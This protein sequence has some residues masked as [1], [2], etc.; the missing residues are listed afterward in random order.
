MHN[1]L[2]STV[3]FDRRVAQSIVAGNGNRWTRLTVYCV[4][5]KAI[6]DYNRFAILPIDMYCQPAKK[7]RFWRIDKFIH[8]VDYVG[9]LV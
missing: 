7:S 4:L 5:S 6:I 9:K 8:G 2:L 1:L 3:A